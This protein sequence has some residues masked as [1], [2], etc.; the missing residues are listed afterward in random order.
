MRAHTRLTPSVLLA[1]ATG[2]LVLAAPS[3]AQQSP[4]GALG[5]FGQNSGPIDIRS[6]KLVI[7]DQKK[8]ALYSGNVVA[9]QGDHTMRAPELEVIYASRDDDPKGTAKGARPPAGSAPPAGFGEDSQQI[10]RIKAR[11]KVVMTTTT[12]GK[13]EQTA[14]CD[15]VDY[16]VAG[17]LVVL[18]GHVHIH[19]GKNVITGSRVT[20]NLKT[21]EYTVDGTPDAA[22]ASG[23]GK[24]SGRI[25]TTLFPQAKGD[26]KDAAAPP[27]AA[28]APAKPP[29]ASS[30]TPTTPR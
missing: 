16:D 28:P 23:A 30:W 29:A 4:A 19:Q 26:G 25:S 22:H 2:L 3:A 13:E 14:T 5:G 24:A 27:A 9:V 12:P 10:K 15:E 21:S 11:T 1:L 18:S 20:L 8:I 7:N 6:D 17:Q